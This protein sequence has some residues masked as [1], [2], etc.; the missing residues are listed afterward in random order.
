VLDRARPAAPDR[1]LARA[2]LIGP[3]VAQILTTGTPLTDAQLDAHVAVLLA[4]RS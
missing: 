3:V 1:A 4:A 2:Q